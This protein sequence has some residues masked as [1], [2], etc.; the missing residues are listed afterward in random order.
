LQR[1]PEFADCNIRQFKAFESFLGR[2][3]AITALMSDQVKS[4]LKG[5]LVGESLILEPNARQQYDITWFNEAMDRIVLRPGVKAYY[6]QENHGAIA[7][8]SNCQDSSDDDL[9][10]GYHDDNE[11]NEQEDDD[12]DDNEEEEDKKVANPFQSILP[13][14]AGIYN[15]IDRESDLS[16][17][18]KYLNMA[19][20]ELLQKQSGKVQTGDGNTSFVLYPETDRRKTDTRKRPATSPSKKGSK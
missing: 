16:I 15:L 17:L 7:T 20:N 4:S 11:D 3:E 9:C 1:F 13:T 8:V 18:K 2:D 14:M 19:R 10:L 5:P 6:S 12:N